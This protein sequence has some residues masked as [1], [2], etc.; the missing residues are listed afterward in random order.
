MKKRM[1]T[2]IEGNWEGHDDFKKKECP[3]ICSIISI[4]WENHKGGGGGDKQDNCVWCECVFRTEVLVF[5]KKFMSSCFFF[6]I[7]LFACFCLFVCLFCQ[8]RSEQDELVHCQAADSWVRLQASTLL[9]NLISL[10]I[11]LL[12][13][14]LF[15]FLIWVAILSSWWVEFHPA[16]RA[17]VKT[18]LL[19]CKAEAIA[20]GGGKLLRQ[21]PEVVS[22]C[23]EAI[24]VSFL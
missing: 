4:K 24:Q 22:V 20:N 15:W 7:C 2:E 3:N 5:F 12:L 18:L 17:A 10:F 11:F 16:D 8:W 13:F 19:V 23:G 21:A 1:K 9:Q 14:N 6:L